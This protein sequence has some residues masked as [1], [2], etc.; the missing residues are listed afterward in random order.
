MGESETPFFKAGFEL[1]LV[2]RLAEIMQT[3]DLRELEL[4]ESD[5]QIRLSRG[6]V[7]VVQ[8]IAPVATT[9][10]AVSQAP[11][12]SPTPP[13]DQHV[14]VIKSPMVGTFFSR[15]NPKSDPF[16]RVGDRIEGDTTVCIIE[17]MKV[18]NEIPAEVSGRIVAVLAEDGESVDF[19]KPLFRVDTRK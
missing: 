14:V 10:P 12:S 8:T 2:R 7:P 17:A 11:T 9:V 5:R 13:D 6:G 16:I 19:G 15:P 18:F 3:F 1:E 4:R